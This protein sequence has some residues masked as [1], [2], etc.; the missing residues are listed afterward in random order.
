[1]HV[2][3]WTT[4]YRY[5]ANNQVVMQ[6][7]PDAS[8]N[9]GTGPVTNIYYDA[10]GRQIALRDANGHLN[11]QTYD[12]NGLLIR[13][14]HADGGVVTYSYDAFGQ[15]T[16]S[17][18]AVGKVTQ[19]N[20]DLLGRLLSTVRPV[21]DVYSVNSF[22]VRELVA[23][24]A[25]TTTNSYDQA[26]RLLSSSNGNAETTR[27]R[28]DLRGNVVETDLP[29][30]NVTPGVRYRSQAAFDT[31]GRKIAD[32]DANGLMATWSYDYFG[33]LT[34]HTDLGGAQFSYSY[35]YDNARQLILQTNARGQSLSYSYDAAGQTTSIVDNAIGQTTSYAW[36]LSGHRIAEKTTQAG[37]VYQDN[38]MAYD[39]LGRMRW[40]A[41]GRSY[42]N[43]SYDAVGN[44]TQIQTHVINGDTS[45]DSNRFFL[46]DA[47][48]RQTVVDAVDA[49]GNIGTQGHQISYD[50]GGNRT[51]DT[52]WGT[53]VATIS[54][55]SQLISYND[56]DAAIYS[57]TPETYQTSQ[58]LTT[59]HYRYDGLNRLRSIERDG[60][61][62]DYRYYD[63]AD[64][65]VQSGPG[66]T[67]PLGY[68]NALNGTTSTGAT[69][70]GNGSETRIKRFDANGRLLQE[71]VLKSDGSAKY[72]LNYQA[73]NG[74]GGYDT[75][76]NLLGY[77]LSNHDGSSY[78]NTYSNTLTRFE[79]Y[80]QTSQVGTSTLLQ[81]GST[82]QSYDVN[83]N[84]IAV[85]DS[86]QGAN[87]RVFVN[88]AAGHA[89]YVN[90]QGHIQREL[91]VNGEMLGRYGD[92]V[93]GKNP[94]TAAGLPNYVNS[95]DFNFSYQPI[96]GNYPSAS[97]GVYAVGGNHLYR[98]RTQ[99]RDWRVPGKQPPAESVRLL[100]ATSSCLARSWQTLLPWHSLGACHPAARTR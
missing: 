31:Q 71:H 20:Y 79:G 76:G 82:T 19:Y 60:V 83:G 98:R 91:I 47:M 6:I 10:L 14:N 12:Q 48:N 37:I 53:R 55:V 24:K 87:S 22:N 85:T 54:G 50:Q 89:L 59:E 81:G 15:K 30:D 61:Q 49:A 51:S 42:V 43:I 56:A 77:S 84:L 69:I 86:A 9:A 45:Q 39:A 28:Y 66:G 44:R 58:G 52:W 40:V 13:E 32:V 63:G 62:V 35:T 70:S 74:V 38:H 90:Q 68:V 29:M 95:A 11:T 93:D 34:G 94:S 36:D 88:D 4:S 7:Q 21:A 1:M 92:L 17:T 67:L 5:N 57:T 33:A 2:T 78:T 99:W 26:G 46:Y 27:Y 16:S 75:A 25:I 65:V 41:D 80:K 73:Q 18:D 8:G 100:V 23:S 97:A 96:S 64:R 72:D 3:P